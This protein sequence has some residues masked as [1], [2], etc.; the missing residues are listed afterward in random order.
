MQLTPALSR[1]DA[2]KASAFSDG[3]VTF[4]ASPSGGTAAAFIINTGTAEAS[5]KPEESYY[6]KF[7]H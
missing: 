6:R 4:S 5:A 1:S 2:G 7:E 3:A